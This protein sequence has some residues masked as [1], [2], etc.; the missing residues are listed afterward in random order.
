MWYAGQPAHAMY[1]KQACEQT[2]VPTLVKK[3]FPYPNNGKYGWTLDRLVCTYCGENRHKARD[4]LK[5]KA[6]NGNNGGYYMD[7][8]QYYHA[9]QFPSHAQGQGRF[10]RPSKPKIR[11]PQAFRTYAN[12]AVNL[13][14]S[15]SSA[16]HD[17]CAYYRANPTKPKRV[18]V[19][20]N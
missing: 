10:K 6:F 18:W 15:S 9:Y 2:T 12:A 5:R 13:A 17:V 11:Q 4:F 16:N 3:K 8:G 20:K 1:R 19:V 14:S 7:Q